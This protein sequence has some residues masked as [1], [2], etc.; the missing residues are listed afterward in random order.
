MFFSATEEPLTLMGEEITKVHANAP[1][2][3]KKA[4][5]RKESDFHRIENMCGIKVN[6]DVTDMDDESIKE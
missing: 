4:H 2:G 3:N 6:D 5:A 1:N